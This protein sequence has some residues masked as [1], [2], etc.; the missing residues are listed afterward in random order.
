VNSEIVRTIHDQERVADLRIIGQGGAATELSMLMTRKGSH[1]RTTSEDTVGLVRRL[2]A[3]YDDKTIALIL[4]KQHRR[5]ATGLT[6]TKTR[7]RD[8]RVSRQISAHEPAGPETPDTPKPL[9][10]PGAGVLGCLVCGVSGS[11]P[12]DRSRSL[13]ASCGPDLA[14]SAACGRLT[15]A[16][17]RRPRSVESVSLA[18][19]SAGHGR[20]IG[21]EWG[22]LVHVCPA[23][24]SCGTDA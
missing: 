8:L 5:T 18:G 2:A 19:I 13:W 15:R 3:C 16:A 20:L 7:V 14:W 17:R 1:T 11:G 22:H 6:W 4:S 10:R 21:S 23:E 9:V 24:S 12:A